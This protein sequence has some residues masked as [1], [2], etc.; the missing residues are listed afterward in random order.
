MAKSILCRW[1]PTLCTKVGVFGAKSPPAK[2]LSWRWIRWWAETLGD[3]GI[4]P[5]LDKL[6]VL[7]NACLNAG[8]LENAL[9]IATVLLDEENESAHYIDALT[10]TNL[11]LVAIRAANALGNREKAIQLLQG[12]PSQDA[13]LE[14]L[15]PEATG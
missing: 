5:P 11:L 8:Y 2:D 13:L 10:K 14:A 15:A 4:M 3:T 9:E 6:E 12:L 1:F 7:A